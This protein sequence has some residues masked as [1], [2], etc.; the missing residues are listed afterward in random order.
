MPA[1]GLEDVRYDSSVHKCST[2]A[3]VFVSNIDMLLARY[4]GMMSL[5]VVMMCL[6]RYIELGGT[7]A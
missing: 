5:V 3:M 1:Q 2:T 7:L 6:P 4:W